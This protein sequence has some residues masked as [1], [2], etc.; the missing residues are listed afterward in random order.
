M[1]LISNGLLVLLPLVF[2]QAVL[3]VNASTASSGQGV[4]FRMAQLLDHHAQ[5]VGV[6]VGIL[7]ALALAS[8]YFMYRMRVEFVAVSRDV[9]REVRSQLFDRLQA[10]SR[11]FFDR[12]HVGDLM[13]VLTNDIS[14][15]RDVLGPGIM[16]PL[17]FVT[18][19]IPSLIAM[20]MISAPMTLLSIVPIL[21]LPLFILVTQRRVY[22]RSKEIQ[23]ILGEM[24]TFAQEHF[25]AARLV[26]STATEEQ[27][28]ERFDQLGKVYFRLNVWLAAIRGLFFPFLT[29]FTRG[30][31]VALVLFAGYSLFYSWTVLSSADFVSFM[32]IQSNI[33]G[34][35]LML[36]WVLPIYQRGSGAYSRMVDLYEEPIDVLDGPVNGPAVSPHA[37]IEFRAL[38]FTYPTM[39]EVALKNVS[40]HIKGGSFVGITGPVA[41]G[42]TTLFRLLNREYEISS[43]QI[44][45]GGRDIRDYR[46]E[47]LRRSIGVVE[48]APFLFSKTVAENVGIGFDDPLME[49][50]EEVSRLADLHESV[51]GFPRQYETVVG[52]R[53]VRLSGGQKQRVA[54]A[55][56][57]LVKRSILLLDDIFSAVDT[58]TERRIFDHMR[59]N[60]KGKTVL[61]VTHRT[62]LL[63]QMDRILYMEEGQIKEDGNHD[64][65]MAL[66][67]S[68]AA[69]VELQSMATV[70]EYQ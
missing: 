18:M 35:V 60:F 61:L 53:G 27:A 30:V 2:R 57:F 4:L 24:S 47:E 34:P 26:K 59:A 51:M 43:N 54:I 23:D 17:F 16:Y 66:G 45:V 13:S 39:S 56:A 19:V 3:S 55:R 11:A 44:F 62:T 12:H 20:F 31:T 63:R 58:A 65:L 49:D 5:S 33:F 15:Y 7:I 48:Q 6:W 1:V 22:V 46:V 67:G 69:L 36:G 25:S 8:A 9:E 32:W 50:I 52:E 64:A 29:L 68:Y 28:L 42:K 40:F 21:L 14:A 41:S 70:E 38:S 10:Q 37:D